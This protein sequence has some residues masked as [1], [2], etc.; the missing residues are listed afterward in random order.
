[1]SIM[2]IVIAPDSFKESA[3]ARTVADAIADG[4]RSA[5]P[6]DT[7][8]SIP[9][10]DGGEGTVDALVDATQG[11]YIATKVS[12]PLGDTVQAQYGILGDSPDQPRTAVIEM[13]A[14]SGL[15]LV[16]PHLRNPTITSTFG[17]GELIVHAMEQDA[18][19]IIL[20]IGGSATNDGGAGMARALG[21][22][23]LDQHNIPLSPGGA[24][25]INLVNIDDANKH[26]ALHTCEILVACDVDNPLCGPSGAS[27]VFAPQK[28]ATPEMVGE[29]DTALRHFANTIEDGLGIP[30]L[31]DIPGAGAA[32]GLGA[33]LLVFTRAQ[34]RPGF[35]IVAEI[36][37]LEEQLM[38][39]DLVITGEGC[40]DCQSIHGKTPVGVAQL[41]KIHGLPVIA[42]AGCLGPGHEELR[43]Y[44]IDQAFAITPP[45][46][47]R[48]EA[49]ANTRK[50]LRNAAA[51]V[52]KQW[53]NSRKRG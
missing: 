3:S 23:L 53:L 25:L 28:G 42:I 32:G 51:R 4:W 8:V 40:L 46:M 50:M 7:L 10:A 37:K 16:P 1:M 30:S 12:G 24:A 36:C 48:E 29:L 35:D 9:M 47:P 19:K 26:P 14:A 22:D 34:L 2:R 44:G 18:K 6:G 43:N 11:R 17:T 21:Y 52:A 15:A 33:G 45:D 5:A 20:G 31:L 39:A 38:G 49:F 27:H 41:A 13:A